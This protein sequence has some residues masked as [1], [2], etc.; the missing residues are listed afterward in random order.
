MGQA[1]GGMLPAAVGVAISPLPIV[2]VVL[3]LVTPRGRVNGPA[4]VGGWWLGLGIVGAIVLSVSNG[5]G[6]TSEGKPATWVSWLEL[7]LGL[8]LFAVAARQWRSRP[9][10]TEDP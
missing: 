8:A 10:G 5:A 9:H 7:V 4:F 2:A 3:M 6:A 1:I